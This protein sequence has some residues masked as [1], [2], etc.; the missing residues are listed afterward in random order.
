MRE[1]IAMDNGTILKFEQVMHMEQRVQAIS[2]RPCLVG[3]WKN[4]DERETM[5]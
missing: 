5:L 3:G 2:F 1:K 4:F